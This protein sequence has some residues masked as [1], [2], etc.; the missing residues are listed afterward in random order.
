MNSEDLLKIRKQAAYALLVSQPDFNPQ[1]FKLE[2]YGPVPGELFSNWLLSPKL[3][4]YVNSLVCRT[5]KGLARLKCTWCKV[6]LMFS[7]LCFSLLVPQE[8]RY[9]GPKC[10]EEVREEHREECREILERKKAE[11]EQEDREGECLL[12]CV[13]GISSKGLSLASFGKKSGPGP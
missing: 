12:E 3:T 5:C 10:Q 1:N 2:C 7:Q 11:E 9:C 8:T 6:S 4:K 13:L